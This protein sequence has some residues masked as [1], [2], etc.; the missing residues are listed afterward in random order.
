MV[1]FKQAFLVL[2]ATDIGNMYP[3]AGIDVIAAPGVGLL[4][5]VSEVYI[6]TD[7]GT[8]WS[9]GGPIYLT[10]ANIADTAPVPA[11]ILKQGGNTT[12]YWQPQIPQ[13][14]NDRHWFENQPFRLK[15]INAQFTGGT[16]LLSVRAFYVTLPAFG[17]EDLA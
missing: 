2:S 1:E 7:D 6:D 15:N 10:C 5:V 4:N 14:S 12:T 8:A 17:V 9:G 3:G 11:S 16:K 13:V